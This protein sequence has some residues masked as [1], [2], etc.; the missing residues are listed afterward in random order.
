MYEED[1]DIADH[2]PDEKDFQALK[3]DQI[4][5]A[6]MLIDEQHP[7]AKTPYDIAFP[8]LCCFC[9]C[10]RKCRA[11]DNEVKKE[12]NNLK[13]S[14]LDNLNIPLSKEAKKLRAMEKKKAQR[15]KEFDKDMQG[16]DPFFS[17]GFGLIAYR[18]TLFSLMMLFFVMSALTYP[19]LDTYKAGTAIDVNTTTS[20]YGMYSLANMG[21][22]SLQCNSVPFGMEKLVLQCPYGSIS[23]IVENGVGINPY[24]SDDA[25][26]TVACLKNEVNTACSDKFDVAKFKASFN[27]DCVGEKSCHFTFN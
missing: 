12:E 1:K 23:A 22:S 3:T 15:N 16:V 13:Q 25:H 14:L 27:T 2:K 20:K 24:K 9:G 18:K 19:I 6:Q 17:L 26:R 11:H 7:I 8:W 4:R 5:M 10:I 21:Y